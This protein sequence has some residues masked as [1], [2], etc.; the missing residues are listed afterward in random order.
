VAS[1]AVARDVEGEDG[2]LFAMI[3]SPERKSLGEIDDFIRSA[4]QEPLEK[5][6]DFRRHLLISRLP[7]FI[8][9]L[10]SWASL[11][12]SGDWRARFAGTFGVTGVAA[13]GSA[14]LTLLSPLTTTLT[15]GIF[16]EDGS[17][18]VRLFYDHRVMDGVQPAMALEELQTELCGAIR[19]ELLAGAGRTHA[20]AA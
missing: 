3:R 16:R 7:R 13:L 19:D 1:L 8:R 14:S 2:V 18:N 10:A 20:A 12:V 9:R 6:G 17:V 11:D 5:F 4:R 15:Y